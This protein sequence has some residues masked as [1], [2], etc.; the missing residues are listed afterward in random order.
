MAAIGCALEWVTYEFARRHN[1]R[2]AVRALASYFETTMTLELLRPRS[3]GI[4]AAHGSD[5]LLADRPDILVIEPVQYNWDL[6]VLDVGEFLA[7]WRDAAHRPSVVVIDSTLSA[8]HWPIGQLLDGLARVDPPLVIDVRSGLKLDQQGLE[9]A[10]L[11]IAVCYGCGEDDSGWWTETVANLPTVRGIRGASLGA[12]ALAA[13]CNGFIFDRAMNERYT[14]SVFSANTRIAEAVSS[15]EGGLFETIAYPGLVSSAPHAVA[16]F[17][18]MKLRDAALADYEKLLGV[19]RWEAARRGIPLAN[20]SSFGFRGHRYEVI[21]PRLSERAG[22]LKF[23]M[24]ARHGPAL[25]RISELLI[26]IAGHP[27]IRSINEAYRGIAPA[28]LD[29]PRPARTE[30]TL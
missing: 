6:S 5:D 9:L 30:R 3:A 28:R 10:N 7:Q 19:V 25:D 23:A 16:P 1:R 21:V 24:G 26:E 20:G 12:E 27:S 11:G 8:T 22:L 2:P 4:S 14:Q 29:L 17:T 18:V 13:L 15:T